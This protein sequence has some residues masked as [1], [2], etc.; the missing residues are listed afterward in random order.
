[1]HG[2]DVAC[3]TTSHDSR[4][5]ATAGARHGHRRLQDRLR[6]R[7]RQRRDPRGVARRRLECRQ[8]APRPGDPVRA[9]PGAAA[10]GRRRARVAGVRRRLRARTAERRDRTRDR[11]AEPRGLGRRT[12]L[13]GAGSR[14][15]RAGPTRERRER[16]G[17]GRMALRGGAGRPQP[18]LPDHEQTTQWLSR[19][20]YFP[21]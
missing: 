21:S 20:S 1:M 19:T 9:W 4:R 7:T 17:A 14:V 11:R 3:S 16:R 13:A 18:D 10:R 2:R 5:Q 6:R 8:L 12:D 15:R